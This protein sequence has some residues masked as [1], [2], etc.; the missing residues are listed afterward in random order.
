MFDETRLR[1]K[2][3]GFAFFGALAFTVIMATL[4]QPLPIPGEPSD[5]VQHISAFAVLTVLAQLAYPGI[6]PRRLFAGLIAL[7]ALI[8]VVQAI[9]AL[10]RE[11]SI[12]DWL[13]D[14]FA[15]TVAMGT[16]ALAKRIFAVEGEEPAKQP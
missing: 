15:V 4:P 8:E 12:L 2:I 6:Q 10:H 7:G 11:A 3:A 5:K 16:A 1:T 9:P 14:C 13:A